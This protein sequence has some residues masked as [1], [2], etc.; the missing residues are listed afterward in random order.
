MSF[1]NTNI[2]DSQ[3]KLTEVPID[4]YTGRGVK[5]NNLTLDTN[6]I[7]NLVSSAAM[8]EKVQGI[9]VGLIDNGSG[10]GVVKNT[11][12]LD[13][14][15]RAFMLSSGDMSGGVQGTNGGNI[16]SANI[17]GTQKD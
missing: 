16:Y 5:R 4:N 8:S 13:T 7:S 1:N 14:D 6:P 12:T 2:L 15:P 17:I 3:S 9:S 11:V 10:T